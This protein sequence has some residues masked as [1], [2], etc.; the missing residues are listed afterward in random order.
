MTLAM[1]LLKTEADHHK[2]ENG[3]Y[4]FPD[5]SYAVIV[6][7]IIHSES[8]V[9]V[10]EFAKQYLDKFADLRFDFLKIGR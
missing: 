4:F 7:G 1:R 10:E 8:S 6:N 9:L 3:G 5:K 2:P